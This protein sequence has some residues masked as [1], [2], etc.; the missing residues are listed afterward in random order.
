MGKVLRRELLGAEF[1]AEFVTPGTD[2]E[3]R[4]AADRGP[5]LD[6]AG[7]AG[8]DGRRE[9][10]D[11]GQSGFSRDGLRLGDRGL[12]RPV[13]PIGLK[14]VIAGFPTE[15][16]LTLVGV[17]LFSPR[18][19]ATA[20]STGWRGRPCAAAGE[21]SGLIPLAFFGLALTIASIGA[22]NI[23]AAALVAPMAMAVAAR[24]EISPF[25]M[26]LMVAHGAVAGA[27]RRSPP[28][29]SSPTA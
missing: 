17:T 3:P 13:A 28:R 27:S 18:R 16:F 8:A 23:A 9:L 11:D 5:G 2:L 22:G 24:A 14:G 4:S 1:E 12:P 20:R 26:T 19:R 21:T 6:L 10:Y 15:L 29:G 7:G 25:L